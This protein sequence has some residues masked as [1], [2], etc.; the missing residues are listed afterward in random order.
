MTEEVLFYL[1]ERDTSV[2]QGISPGAFLACGRQCSNPQALSVIAL[3]T[4]R[5]VSSEHCQMEPQ[6]QNN[7]NHDLKAQVQQSDYTL[8]F[9]YI[10]FR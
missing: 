6:N 4:E 9:R 3:R 2:T 10:F 7:S 8:G 5:K 1:L